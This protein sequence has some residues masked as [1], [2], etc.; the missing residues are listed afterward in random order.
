MKVRRVGCVVIALLS[1]TTGQYLN[2]SDA[3][4]YS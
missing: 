3:I 1:P 4:Y 2:I